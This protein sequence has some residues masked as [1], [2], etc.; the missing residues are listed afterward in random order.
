MKMKQIFY[1]LAFSFCVATVNAQNAIPAGYTKAS[2]ALYNGNVLQGYVKDNIKKS[3]SVVYMDDAGDNKKVVE[4]SDI[5]TLTIDSLHFVCIRGDFFKI[6]CAGKLNFLQK[7][8]N[9][10]GKPTYNGTEA[11][12]NNGTQGKVGDY[13]FYSDQKL[14][15]LSKKNMEMCINTDLAGCAEAMQLAKACNGDMAKLSAAVETYNNYAVK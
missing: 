6:I 14:Q 10:S 2:I 12:F 11:I 8:S 4:G 5:N 1:A 7:S 9:S 13:Y 15:L 3:S